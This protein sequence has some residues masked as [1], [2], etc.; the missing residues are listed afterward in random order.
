MRKREASPHFC[1]LTV[2][3]DYS[4]GIYCDTLLFLFVC[5]CD[6]LLLQDIDNYFFL[7]KKPGE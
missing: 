6:T 4:L 2:N 5:F 7:Y 3:N 1:Y